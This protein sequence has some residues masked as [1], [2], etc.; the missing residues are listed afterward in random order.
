MLTATPLFWGNAIKT[1]K[2]KMK[3]QLEELWQ[4]TQKVAAEE[5][6]QPTPPDFTTI[7]NEKVAQAIEKIDKGP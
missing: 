7:S 1:N 3:K 2:E 5:M 6:D 4:Y